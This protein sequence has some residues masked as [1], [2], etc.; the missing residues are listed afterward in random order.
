MW[1]KRVYIHH[2]NGKRVTCRLMV[3]IVDN[4]KRA[5]EKKLKK[6][7]DSKAHGIC[8]AHVKDA[9]D[10]NAIPSLVDKMN[11][12]NISTT[13]NVFSSVYYLVKS[14]RPLSDIEDLIELQTILG[15]AMGTGLHSRFTATKI[16][17]HISTEM[18]AHIFSK[19]IEQQSKLCLVIDEASTVSCKPVLI[20]YIKVEGSDY[21]PT[22]FLDL[23]ELKNQQSKTIHNAVLACLKVSGFT[24]EYLEKHLI[25]F[26]SD[27][28]SVML[29]SKS[30]VA[31]RMRECFPNI[32]QLTCCKSC[33]EC[34]S[35]TLYFFQN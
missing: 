34:I 21:A 2:Q 20:I 19:T 12:K 29:G 25:G 17:E 30:G 31:T 35:S 26:C 16:V 27:G 13:C 10:C 23:V 28:A 11:E 3:V 4:S 24:T 18:K 9:M 6:H 5:F 15:C 33:L 7:F 14:C 1:E 32:V 22:I 8:K